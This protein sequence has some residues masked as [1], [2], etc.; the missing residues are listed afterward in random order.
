MVLYR[1]TYRT[2]YYSL[3]GKFLFEGRKHSRGGDQQYISE[4]VKNMSQK[5][6]KILFYA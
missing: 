6:Q 3:L 2:E 5:I 4:S 1:I